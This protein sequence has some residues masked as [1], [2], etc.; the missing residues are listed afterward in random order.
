[1]YAPVA[2]K[3]AAARKAMEDAQRQVAA[4]NEYALAT[5]GKAPLT[6]GNIKGIEAEKAKLLPDDHYA[7]PAEQEAALPEH[8]ADAEADQ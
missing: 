2:E 7:A 5:D 1:M 4:S 3:Q 6:G 8:I